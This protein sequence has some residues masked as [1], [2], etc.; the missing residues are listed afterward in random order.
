MSTRALPEPNENISPALSAFDALRAEDEPWL[1]TCFVPPPDFDLIAGA[2]SVLVF[3]EAG[4]G[5]TALYQALRR[6]LRPA[7][8]KPDRLVAEWQPVS[9]PSKA[10]ADSL[11]AEAQLDRVLSVC[12]AELSDFVARWPQEFKHAPDDVQNTLAWFAHKYLVPR[13]N[14]PH[15]ETDL[16]RPA[17]DDFL[18]QAEP[19]HRIA[20]LVKAVGEIGLSG[21]CV[22]VGP[23]NLG[24]IESVQP[25]L[26]A[27]LSSLNLFEQPHFVYKLVLPTALSQSLLTASSVERRRLDPIPLRWFEPELIAVV[28]RRFVLATDGKAAHLDDVCQDKELIQWLSRCGGDVPRGWLEQVRPLA[29][30]YIS[31]ERPLTTQEWQE[32]REHRPPRLSVDIETGRVTVGYRQIKDIGQ[33]EMALLHYLYQYRDRICTREE[34]YHKAYRPSMYPGGDERRASPADYQGLLDTALWR[35]R[36]A[37]EPEPKRPVFVVTRRGKGVKLENAW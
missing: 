1:D 9:L 29:A 21:V 15:Q 13:E 8:H 6:R 3:G 19:K 4:S 25:G 32:I 11:T 10:P 20:E 23:D 26:S 24:D 37:I 2:R 36:K 28:E 22:L 31:R 35:L 12:M 34:L 33:V 16:A 30:H 27:L 5:K 7:G 14:I 18:D 17:R